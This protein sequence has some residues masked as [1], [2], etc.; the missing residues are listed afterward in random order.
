MALLLYDFPSF[1]LSLLLGK[2][3]LFFKGKIFNFC[4][5]MCWI[6][7]CFNYFLCFHIL[8]WSDL[9]CLLVGLNT[10]WIEVFDWGGSIC[11]LVG[12]I[13]FS[14]FSILFFELPSLILI[15]VGLSYYYICLSSFYQWKLSDKYN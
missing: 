1:S 2:V 7:L 9:I 4:V 8:F 6:E 14:R 12:L 5:C 15:Y 13:F 10:C 11:L 3:N